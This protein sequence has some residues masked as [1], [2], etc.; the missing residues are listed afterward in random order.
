MQ[1]AEATYKM[2]AKH[3]IFLHWVQDPTQ[4]MV[5]WRQ[6]GMR[7][8]YGSIF[9][10]LVIACFL[11]I[12]MALFFA[13]YFATESHR[14]EGIGFGRYAKENPDHVNEILD[15]EGLEEVDA[16]NIIL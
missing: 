12:T 16:K 8:Y 6:N 14:C 15:K 7:M 5:A 9:S 1:E 13:R 4:E 2:Q 11:S 10:V 3:P